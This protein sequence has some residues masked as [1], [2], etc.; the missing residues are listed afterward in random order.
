SKGTFALAIQAFHAGLAQ[1]PYYRDG[2]YNLTNTFLVTGQKDSMLSAAR[3]LYAVDPMNRRTIQLLA[4]AFQEHGKQDSTL[5]YITLADS[6]LPFE[7]TVGAFTPGDQNA[8][9][10]GLFTNFHAT[11]TA[12]AKVTFEF[13]DAH[14]KVIATQVQ[15]VPALDPSGN[16]P[17]QLQV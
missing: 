1:N 9:L 6:L 15:D 13:L 3:A 5:H 17:F 12:P 14:G 7:V 4:E 16:Q 10:S 8:S 2:L 11:K